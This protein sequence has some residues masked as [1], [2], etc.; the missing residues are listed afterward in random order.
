MLVLSI[1]Y[2]YIL[3]L[4][5]QSLSWTGHQSIK[6]LTRTAE[7]AGASFTLV[8]TSMGNFGEPAHGGNPGRHRENMQTLNWINSG[9]KSICQWVRH[10]H[11]N[12]DILI[13]IRS[14]W[15]R[16]K[17]WQNRICL[18]SREHTSLL[19]VNNLRYF[20]AIPTYFRIHPVSQCKYQI[21]FML[22]AVHISL[23]GSWRG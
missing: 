20:M 10:H 23:R 8:F 6:G 17:E 2:P 3:L 18:Q 22:W 21:C 9:I 19:K 4:M 7:T 14:R 13:E 1:Y 15:K 12:C 16:R 5:L 11:G